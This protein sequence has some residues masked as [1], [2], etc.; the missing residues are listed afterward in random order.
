MPKKNSYIS[1]LL[2]I[3][4]AV[5]Y[6]T[7]AYYLV[8]LIFPDANELERTK[9]TYYYRDNET[10]LFRTGLVFFIGLVTILLSYF[11]LRNYREIFRGLFIGA[12]ITIFFGTTSLESVTPKTLYA[13]IIAAMAW[14]MF[15]ILTVIMTNASKE[16]PKTDGNNKKNLVN[17]S[18]KT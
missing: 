14:F 1:P 12:S 3:A 9:Y 18:D 10:T 11:S 7:L 13:G 16:M 17:A 6:T 4:I 2:T 5:L 15:L 8:N